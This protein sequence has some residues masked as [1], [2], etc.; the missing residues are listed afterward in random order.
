MEIILAVLVVGRNLL[1]L[2]VVNLS[3]LLLIVGRLA[4]GAGRVGCCR[5]RRRR[6]RR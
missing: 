6:R 1:L 4:L 3:R 5:G 2:L